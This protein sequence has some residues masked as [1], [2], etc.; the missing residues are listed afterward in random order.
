MHMLHFVISL[1]KHSYSLVILYGG[2]ALALRDYSLLSKFSTGIDK[3]ISSNEGFYKC[4]FLWRKCRLLS[5]RPYAYFGG[6]WVL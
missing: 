4:F 6:S 1:I 2:L 3:V 5:D